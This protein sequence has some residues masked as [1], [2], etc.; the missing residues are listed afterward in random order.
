MQ[1]MVYNLIIHAEYVVHCFCFVFS[2]LLIGTLQQIK[3][4]ATNSDLGIHRYQ[5]WQK[6]ERGLISSLKMKLNKKAYRN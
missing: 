1:I 2:K 3:N 6:R 5:Q 4:V